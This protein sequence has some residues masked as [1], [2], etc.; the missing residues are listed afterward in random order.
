VVELPKSSVPT[1]AAPEPP[2]PPPVGIEL[3]IG[4]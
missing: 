1:D 2:E 3:L 4:A